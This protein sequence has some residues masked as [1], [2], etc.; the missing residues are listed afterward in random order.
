MMRNEAVVMFA[1]KTLGEHFLRGAIGLAAL[2]ATLLCER[3]M[4]LLSI[5]LLPIGLLA[6]RGCPTCWTMGL[7]ETI[8][9]RASG[10]GARKRYVCKDGTCTRVTSE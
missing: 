5:V 9:A 6:L 10:R 3:D 4:P 2:V 8:A 1:S 7:I